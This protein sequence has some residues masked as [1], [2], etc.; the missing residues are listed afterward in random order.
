M[1]LVS[2]WKLKNLVSEVLGKYFILV[3]PLL[4]ITLL[5]IVKLFQK[6]LF[7]VTLLATLASS[8]AFNG[9]GKLNQLLRQRHS[10]QSYGTS[11]GDA[12]LEIT[13]IYF[14]IKFMK[15]ISFEIILF[16]HC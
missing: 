1:R 12:L 10:L 9:G 15:T 3:S 16:E 8:G 14:F 11:P 4:L 2:V 13:P 5:Q 7:L 6:M